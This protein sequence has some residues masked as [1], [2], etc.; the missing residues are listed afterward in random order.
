[1]NSNDHARHGLGS[2][3]SSTI[4]LD[5]KAVAERWGISVKALQMWR[6]R[7]DGPV[8]C[9]F[10]NRV[11]YRLSDIEAFELAQTRTSTSGRTK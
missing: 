4:F 10:G 2:P 5:E 1:M 3:H 7:G 9:K 11:R 8:F 6:L